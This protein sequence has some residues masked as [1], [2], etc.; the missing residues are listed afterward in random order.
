MALTG[1]QIRG[2]ESSNGTVI[3]VQRRDAKGLEQDKLKGMEKRWGFQE[4]ISK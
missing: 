1:A 3:I 2:R 4:M